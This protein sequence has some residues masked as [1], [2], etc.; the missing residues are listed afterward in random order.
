[1][2]AGVGGLPVLT[3]LRGY[4]AGWLR[5]DLIAGL[6]VCAIL[7]PEALAYATIAGVSPRGQAEAARV[8]YAP[9]PEELRGRVAEAVTELR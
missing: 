1:M 6:T 4:R 9:L 5:G 7:V 8:G 2:R 3:S